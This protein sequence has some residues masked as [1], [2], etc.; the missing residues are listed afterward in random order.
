[1]V[2][3]MVVFRPDG[4]VFQVPQS[5][6]VTVRPLAPMA[7]CIPDG[8]SWTGCRLGAGCETPCYPLGAQVYYAGDRPVMVAITTVAGDFPCYR[9]AGDGLPVFGRAGYLGGCRTLAQCY[10]L[11]RSLASGGLEG[12][13]K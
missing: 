2:G 11:A 9:A 3:G 1:M 13:R 6:R 12:G 10:Q 5:G 7:K 4:T 8:G